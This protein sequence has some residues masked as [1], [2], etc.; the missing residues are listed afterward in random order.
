MKISPTAFGTNGRDDL[1]HKVI[2]ERADKAPRMNYQ[3]KQGT[4]M[5]M[6]NLF[7]L[8]TKYDLA[9]ESRDVGFRGNIDHFKSYLANC[10]RFAIGKYGPSKYHAL[11]KQ[12]GLPKSA[13]SKIHN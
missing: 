13:A 8:K 11:R 12:A 7:R 4:A 2:A 6:H 9:K 5:F 3:S 10:P 1:W